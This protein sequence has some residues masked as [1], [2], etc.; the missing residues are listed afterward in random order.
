MKQF[1]IKRFGRLTKWSLVCGWKSWFKFYVIWSLIWF[2]IFALNSYSSHGMTMG[3]T[4][5]ELQGQVSMIM[6]GFFITWFTVAPSI[7]FAGLKTKQQ[8]IGYFSLPATN[9]EKYVASFAVVNI[10]C[11]AV[12]ILGG[13]T[14]DI[15]RFVFKALIGDYSSSMV[16]VEVMKS[17]I[18]IP[19]RHIDIN[20]DV[21][22]ATIRWVFYAMS[23]G[24]VFGYSLFLLGGSVFRKSQWLF[25]SIFG[26][27]LLFVVETIVSG[28]GN[29]QLDDPATLKMF[30]QIVTAILAALS[31]FNVWASYKVFTRMQVINNKW[32]NL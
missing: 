21:N 29:G 30:C 13:W 10:G 22:A 27:I 26:T 8:R 9:L 23:M 7:M 15:L 25:T 1:D 5:V 20:G 31:I 6:I 18:D 32:I 3:G 4:P 17:M 28:T 11:L 16:M 24:F 19:G 12:T 14:V 2:F